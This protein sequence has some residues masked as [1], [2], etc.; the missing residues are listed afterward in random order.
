MVIEIQDRRTGDENKIRGRRLV[1]IRPAGAASAVAI[2]YPVPLAAG[3]VITSATRSEGELALTGGCMHPLKPSV[4]RGIGGFE[5][6]KINYLP[7]RFSCCP[8]CPTSINHREL[9][10]E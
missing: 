3:G 7:M 2:R 9:P 1:H 5:K 6:G 8:L 4:A 10:P